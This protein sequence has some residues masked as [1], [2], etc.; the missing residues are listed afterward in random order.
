MRGVLARLGHRL[1]GH[2]ISGCQRNV[3]DTLGFRNGIFV[4]RGHVEYLLIC[5]CGEK[6]E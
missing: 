3:T 5:S 1:R 4:E 6:W 2:R